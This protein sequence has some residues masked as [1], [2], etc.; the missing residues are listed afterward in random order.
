MTITWVDPKA[1]LPPHRLTHPEKFQDLVEEFK[2]NNWGRGFPAL[3][4]YWDIND[5]DKKIQLISGTHRWNAA[6]KADILI[7]VEIH[8]REFLEEIW[9]TD[10]WLEMMQN[11]LV[12]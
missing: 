9:G 12:V 3:I 4:G 6:I 11:P 2:N 1:C 8:S 10:E 7:P 5:D